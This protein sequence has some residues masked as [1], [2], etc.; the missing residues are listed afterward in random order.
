[1]LSYPEAQIQ[2][3]MSIVVRCEEVLWIWYMICVGGTLGWA[4]Q[5]SLD[6]GPSL[7]KSGMS[8]LYCRYLDLN[9]WLWVDFDLWPAK[10]DLKQI[11]EAQLWLILIGAFWGL[12]KRQPI[13]IQFSAKL[14][15]LKQVETCY[16]FFE[17]NGS[18]LIQATAK[19]GLSQSQS[20]RG[21][22]KGEHILPY[23]FSED[24]TGIS[25]TGKFCS[26]NR[27]IVVPQNL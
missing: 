9:R 10:I 25:V 17:I 14:I 23:V 16:R 18:G 5:E 19:T 22:D 27:L 24:H 11:L 15:K 21:E 8:T 2:G 20:Q 26:R 3:G 13:S 12:V 4:H 7:I 6:D 1:M